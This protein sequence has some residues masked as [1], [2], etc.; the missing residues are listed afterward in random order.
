MG[1][2]GS[3]LALAQSRY[4][5][6]LL[7]AAHPGLQVE[8]RV[9]VTT[10]DR[11]QDESLPAIGGKGVFTMEIE[12]ALQNGEIDFAVHSLKDLP[13]DLPEGLCLAAVPERGP[14]N[15]V[16]ILNATREKR[17]TSLRVGTSSLRRRAMILH[18]HPHWQVQEIRGNIDTR[19]RRLDD[20]HFNAIVL[21]C[22]GL[23]RLGI[24]QELSERI[25]ELD[26][27]AFIPAPGQGALALEARADDESTLML[28]E[29]IEDDSARAA[30][31]AERTVVR[32]LNAGCSTPLGAYA[33]AEGGVLSLRA[34]VLSADGKERIDAQGKGIPDRATDVGHSVAQKLLDQGA[35]ALLLQ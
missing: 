27:E 17:D 30:I 15:D 3:A 28:L 34:C 14:A 25:V 21:A 29:T 24:D 22:A 20:E 32:L 12:N 11:H 10:G 5:V 1:T 4:V 26:E 35:A 23:K 9:I 33:V 31:I 16:L 19:L 7:Q 8:E 6:S 18:S 13:P 2:R